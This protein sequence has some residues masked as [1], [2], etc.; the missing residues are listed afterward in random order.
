MHKDQ[1][2]ADLAIDVLARQ[3][4][5]RARQAGEAFEEALKAVLE[6]EPA[7]SLRSCATDRTATRR[8]SGGR[9]TLRASGAK[10][11][12]EPDKK[13]VVEPDKRSIV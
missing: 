8:R 3:A 7:G 12:I 4:G 1:G 13:S 9:R 10:N 5:T 11:V 6:T 2:V